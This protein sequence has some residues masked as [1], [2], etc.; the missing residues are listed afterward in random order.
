MEIKFLSSDIDE[1]FIE[2]PLFK[3]TSPA[4][5]NSCLHSCNGIDHCWWLELSH[6]KLSKIF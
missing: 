3:E 2:A 5:K 6:K 1:T 4:L